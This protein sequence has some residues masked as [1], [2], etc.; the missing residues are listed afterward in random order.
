MP[1]T[2]F[3]NAASGSIVRGLIRRGAILTWV[4]LGMAVA[5]LALGAGLRTW[6]PR[7]NAAEK[8]VLIAK[9]VKGQFQHNVVER[10]EVMSSSNVEIRC[11]VKARNTAGTALLEV[12]PE[13]T[14]VSE[15]DV[16]A[17]LDATA[18]EQ[19]T[20]QQRIACNTKEAAMIDAQNTYEAAEIA[21]KEY[22]EGTFFQEEQTIKSE[23]LIAE[24]NLR[25][26]QEYIKYS[27]RLAAR[28]YVTSQQM[29]GDR[30][31]VEKAQTEL[32]T[33]KTKLRVLRN[34]TK[35]K[36]LK[37]LESDIKSAEALWKSEQSS[38]DL[39][40]SKLKDLEAQVKLC[41]IKAP[42]SGI[43][44]HANQRSMRGDSEFIVEPGALVRENQVLFR[45]PDASDMHVQAKINEARVTLVREGMTASIRLDAFGDERFNGK[46]TKVN[47]YPEPGGWFSSQ[48]KEYATQIKILDPP[49][50]IRTGLTAEVTIHVESIDDVNMMPMQAVLEKDGKF[51]C[52]VRENEKWDPRKITVKASNEKFVTYEGDVP[53]GSE[54]ALNPREL[55]D[56]VKFPELPPTVAPDSG[57][58]S[59]DEMAQDQNKLSAANAPEAPSPKGRSVG[60]SS[61]EGGASFDPAA[62]ATMIFDRLD[63][64][65]DGNI[66][67]DEIPADQAA[68]MAGNDTNSDGNISRDELMN[69]IRSRSAAGTGRGP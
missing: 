19:E 39:E 49:P 46:V 2:N 62:I 67:Q 61:P 12:V 65:K 37:Q 56:R 52:I 28:G 55:L 31:A 5:I 20:V 66:S 53:E 44:I 25:R 41:V 8:K 3:G 54:V 48:I 29:E 30:F 15:G 34:Y 64:N 18:L 27:E 13:G 51:Y 17:R 60:N 36:T 59:P 22:V 32:E 24:E 63:K 23:I 57:F 47:E 33:A 14:I 4:V 10:G 11:G 21:K 50:K 68:R 43:V 40:L 38:Y 16:I 7:R 42:Q 9:V 1:D 45:F 35:L 58:G 26:A 69:A 6:L